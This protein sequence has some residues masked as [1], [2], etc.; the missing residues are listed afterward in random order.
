[1]KK[2]LVVGT[3]GT[4]ASKKSGSIG[5]DSPFKILDCVHYGNIVFDC[6]CP[7]CVLSENMDFD[8]WQ[9]LIDYLMKVNFEE[10]AGV[11]IL[12]GSDTL[13]YTGAVLGNIFY[14]KKMILVA[15]DK[16]VEEEDSN[17]VENFCNAVEFII[18]GVT[19]VFISYD[20]L[21]RAVRTV[22]ANARD[23]FIAAG[24]QGKLIKNPLLHRKNILVI[25][26][27]VGINYNNYNLDGVDLVLHEMYHSATAPENVKPFISKCRESGVAFNFVTA[28]SSAD[29]ESAKDFENIIFDSTLENAY[30]KAL[31]KN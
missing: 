6:V 18:D 20:R 2:I 26:P 10:Y 14:D 25:K 24:K 3:G 8:L 31:L 4:I 21:Y 17:G 27:Y 28:K 22:S 29:Y 23:E 13:A 5:L 1:M 16:P 9:Q 30:A 15:S 7:F 19:G 12:H 11:I